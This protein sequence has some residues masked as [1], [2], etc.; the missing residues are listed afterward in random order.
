VDE[1]AAGRERGLDLPDPEH[2]EWIAVRAPASIAALALVTDL[3]R[4]EAEVL[5][6]ALE[7]RDAVIVIDDSLAR[8]IAGTL[9]L[10]FRGTLG[11]LLDAKRA[12]IVPAVAP[13]LDR[14]D[15]LR[16]RLDSATR[17]DVLALAGE[18]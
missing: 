2:I 18:R 5:A 4:G 9:D 14:L 11:L 3:G 17:R 7:T 6:L 15:E 8:R 16:F 12:G 13:L 10:R 1:L